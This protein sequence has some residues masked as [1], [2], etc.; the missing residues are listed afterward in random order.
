MVKVIHLSLLSP[1]DSALVN[2]GWV[3][4]GL[5]IERC[6][7]VGQGEQDFRCCIFQ[8]IQWF[9]LIM[10]APFEYWNANLQK[11]SDCDQTLVVESTCCFSPWLTPFLD[12]IR[13]FW[14][15]K[16][17][18]MCSA[19]LLGHYL[20]NVSFSSGTFSA[21]HVGQAAITVISLFV[22]HKKVFG[23]WTWEATPP[24]EDVASEWTL[25]CFQEGDFF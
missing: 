3:I 6:I 8:V 9:T 17:I 20:L 15:M 12:G 11:A 1:T 23:S 13:L 4:V 2:P 16:H 10:K 22:D 7:R 18:T 21:I 25:Q 5:K 19:I 24:A 14:S